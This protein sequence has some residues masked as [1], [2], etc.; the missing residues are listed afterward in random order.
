VNAVHF[1]PIRDGIT[2]GFRRRRNPYIINAHSGARSTN[3]PGK[4]GLSSKIGKH[5]AGQSR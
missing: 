5:L 4:H 3:D 2:G 1:A